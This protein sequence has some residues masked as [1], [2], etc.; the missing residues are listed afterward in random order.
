MNPQNIASHG[1]VHLDGGIEITWDSFSDSYL[2]DIRSNGL[3][4]QNPSS[5]E[6]IL[7]AVLTI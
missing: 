1:A 3:G 2:F 7:E 4:M 5:A 6:N